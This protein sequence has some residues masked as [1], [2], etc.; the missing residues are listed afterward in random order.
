MRHRG[1]SVPLHTLPG[2]PVQG[3]QAGSQGRVIPFLRPVEG[4]IRPD[5]R[6]LPY[7]V[8]DLVGPLPRGR[9]PGPPDVLLAEMCEADLQVREGVQGGTPPAG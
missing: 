8:H 9:G 3:V 6:T 4:E 5:P 1:K 7:H 2:Y